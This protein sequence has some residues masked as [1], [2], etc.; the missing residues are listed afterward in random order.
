MKPVL[1]LPSSQRVCPA[2][3]GTGGDS[4]P[5][6]PAGPAPPSPPQPCLA[7]LWRFIEPSGLRTNEQTLRRCVLH[8]NDKILLLHLGAILGQASLAVN[9]I[10]VLITSQ[11]QFA[12]LGRGF[13]DVSGNKFCLFI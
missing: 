12:G 6:G 8:T 10:Y 3:S 1:L 4:H 9:F 11:L 5:P 2:G 7:L 13:R